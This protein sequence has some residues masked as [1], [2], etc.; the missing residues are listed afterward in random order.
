MGEGR[1]SR[2]LALI[3]GSAM[4]LR[5][6]DFPGANERLPRDI[7][8]REVWNLVADRMLERMLGYKAVPACIAGPEIA[9]EIVGEIG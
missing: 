1:Y 5:N 3:N 8:Q 4:Q 2:T 7:L 6:S 9:D